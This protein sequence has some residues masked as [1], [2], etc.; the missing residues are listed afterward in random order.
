MWTNVTLIV[1]QPT[2][3]TTAVKKWK[4]VQETDL[5]WTNTRWTNVKELQEEY[6]EDYSFSCS[7][8]FFI[9]SFVL[10]SDRLLTI[11][12]SFL[13]VSAVFLFNFF[14]WWIWCLASKNLKRSRLREGKV[15]PLLFRTNTYNQKVTAVS[16]QLLF[17]RCLFRSY[18]NLLE[19][20]SIKY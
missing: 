17:N 13:L 14:S 16:W 15:V 10:F 9:F 12:V 8:I 4:P 1:C 3:G 20:N 6:L 5:T 18:F 19:L 11:F 7:C 2:F